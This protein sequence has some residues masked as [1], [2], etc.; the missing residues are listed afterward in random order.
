MLNIDLD[1]TDPLAEISTTN[2]NYAEAVE[3][4]IANIPSS[5]IDMNYNIPKLTKSLYSRIHD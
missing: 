1:S 3:E 2:A 4:L 5:V